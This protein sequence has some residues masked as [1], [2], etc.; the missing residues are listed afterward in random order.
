MTAVHARIE[1]VNVGSRRRLA[2]KTL[3]LGTVGSSASGTADVLI[4][5]ISRTGLLLETPAVLALD[6]TIAINIPESRGARAVVK[7]ASGQFYGCEFVRPISQAAVSAC[8]L[9]ADYEDKAAEKDFPV[10]AASGPWT[11]SAAV[12]SS[13]DNQASLGTKMRWILLLTALSWLI[14]AAAAT[15][16]WH[17]LN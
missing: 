3:S 15:S 9:K 2:R 1:D 5:N 17:Y 12:P 8:Q 14:V 11:A 7:W 6:E 10:A 4:R 16:A 13:I